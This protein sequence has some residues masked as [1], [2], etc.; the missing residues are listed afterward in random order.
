V[1]KLEGQIVNTYLE[2]VAADEEA[3]EPNTQSDNPPSGE[4]ESETLPAWAWGIIGA[5]AFVFLV[6]LG[7][8]CAQRR[9]EDKGND[10]IT[11]LGEHGVDY[12]P[13]PS[14]EH[15]NPF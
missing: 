9:R 14:S 12:L 6:I 5:A 7:F 13:P 11:P 10:E 8:L 15:D 2:N 3:E 1:I 4:G